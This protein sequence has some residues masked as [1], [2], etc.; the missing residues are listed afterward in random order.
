MKN[1]DI[2]SFNFLVSK[3]K[4]STTVASVIP[5]YKLKMPLHFF[6]EALFY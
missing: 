4:E 6:A 5:T 3:D 1:G 2:L